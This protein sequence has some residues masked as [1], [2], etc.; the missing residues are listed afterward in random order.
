MVAKTTSVMDRL[1]DD[2]RELH[3]AAESHP[4]QK[5]Q[6]SGQLPKEDYIAMLGQMYLVHRSLE[7]HLRSHA[8]DHAISTVV[9]DFQ[10][11]EPYLAED[12]EFFGIDAQS[13]EPL[14]A[15][16]R[17]MTR[18]DEL[19]NDPI[20]LLGMHYVLEGSNNGSTYIAKAVKHIYGLHDGRGMKYL[21]PYGDLQRE[22]WADFK[23]DMSTIEFTEAQIDHMVEAAKE[24][25]IALPTIFD[26]LSA[27]RA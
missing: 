8:K 27:I 21:D 5:A 19:A 6:V 15:T 9:H 4:F 24:L 26:D 12:L 10:Y 14:P 13:V 7:Q 25:F 17:L 23:R 18:F 2:T 16:S 20:A 11:Q 22:R 3:T 1:R